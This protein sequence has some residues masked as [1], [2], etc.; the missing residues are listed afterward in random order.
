MSER[1][2]WLMNLRLIPD[3]EGYFTVAWISQLIFRENS[4]RITFKPIDIQ[5]ISKSGCYIQCNLIC[6]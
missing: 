3:R 6:S 4:A 1:M 2:N 5:L